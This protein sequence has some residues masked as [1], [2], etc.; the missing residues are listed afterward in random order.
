M[1]KNERIA[2]EVTVGLERLID[3][4]PAMV[5]MAWGGCTVSVKEGIR[6]M[7]R[8]VVKAALESEQE[9]KTTQQDIIEVDTKDED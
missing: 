9:E 6:I 5:R 3:N 8:G 1:E 7:I 4:A 2:D